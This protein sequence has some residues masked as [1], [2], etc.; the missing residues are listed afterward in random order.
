MTS[1]TRRPIIATLGQ[2][3]DSVLAE[4]ISAGASVGQRGL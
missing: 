4:I 1:A 2:I 3:D